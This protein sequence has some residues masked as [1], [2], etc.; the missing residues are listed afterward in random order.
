MD[1]KIKLFTGLDLEEIE[2][3]VNWF[4][5]TGDKRNKKLGNWIIEIK[6]AVTTKGTETLF[7]VMI[8]YKN[9]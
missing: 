6:H 7:C 3:Q 8:L 2:K 9:L 4:L 5:E 1:I